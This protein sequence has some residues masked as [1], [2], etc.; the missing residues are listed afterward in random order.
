MR[1][2]SNYH[3]GQGALITSMQFNIWQL[4]PRKWA[5]APTNIP[6]NMNNSAHYALTNKRFFSIYQLRELDALPKSPR[7]HKNE[8]KRSLMYHQD[9][10]KHSLHAYQTNLFTSKREKCYCYERNVSETEPERSITYQQQM[11][12]TAQYQLIR[13]ERDWKLSHS[14]Q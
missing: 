2:L 8:P 12:L 7:D 3:N 13:K 14:A 4:Q 11:S 5:I 9:E 10:H 6:A 1:S